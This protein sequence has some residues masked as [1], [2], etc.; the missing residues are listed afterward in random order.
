MAK[1]PEKVGKYK[2]VSL[3]GKGA[4]GVVYEAE[5]P[6]LKRKVILKKLTVRDKEFRERFRLEADTMMDLRSDYIV[7]M[8]DHFREGNSWY[9]AMEFIEGITLSDLIQ[10]NGPLEYSLFTYIMGCTSKAVEYI[11]KRGII[12]RDIKPSNIY[13]SRNGDVKLGDFGISSS[14][15]RDIK[16]TDSG[17]AMGTPSY[18]APEQFNDSSSVDARADIFSLGVTLYESLAGVKPFLSEEYT[19]LKHEIRKGKYKRLSLLRKGIPLSVRWVIRRSLFTGPSFRFREM[20]SIRRTFDREV[21]RAGNANGRQ[22]LITLLDSGKKQNKTILTEI[23]RNIEKKRKSFPFRVTVL[24]TL[25]FAAGVFIYSGGLQRYLFSETYGGL[26]MKMIPA[27]NDGR[28]TLYS[29][30]GTTALMAAE[31]SF[32]RKGET[33]LFIREGSYIIKIESGSHIDWRSLYVPDFRDN[34]GRKME[35]TYLSSPMEQFPLDLS[36]SV[37]NRFSSVDLSPETEVFIKTGQQ[38][39]PLTDTILSQL[40]TGSF[41]DLKF[42]SEG[43]K[44]GFYRI[45]TEF[46][47]TSISLDVLLSPIPSYLK[48]PPMEKGIFTINGGDEYFSL[49]SLKYEKFIIDNEK[50]QILELLPGKYSL[51]LTLE[52]KQRKKVLIMNSGQ[53]YQ[54]IPEP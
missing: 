32:N 6:T 46:Y 26:I 22:Q 3:V 14:T 20:K 5:H 19:A 30:D 21:R 31:G 25:L 15:S 54:F 34:R 10:Q 51:S 18:M 2:I 23:H 17:S 47:Q 29:Y 37:R 52:E 27:V 8:Y 44:D 33:S 38:W 7:D 13:L 4:M 11:H 41:I 9:I 16:I 42:S 39:Q 1:I 48:I 28:Y 36:Y 50:T 35:Q 53:E 24:L 49:R 43:Y 40:K 45:E 12:H